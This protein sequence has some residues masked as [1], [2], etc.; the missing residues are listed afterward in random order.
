PAAP[1]ETPDLERRRQELEHFA[2]H[3][4]RKAERLRRQEE[5]LAR[6]GER[7]PEAPAA[8]AAPEP[9]V[10]RRE[11]LEGLAEDL[12]EQVRQRDG[13]IGSGGAPGAGWSRSGPG[14]RAG[15]AAASAPPSAG[16]SRR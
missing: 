14:A 9:G 7:P 8:P 13:L 12:R 5:M 15:R 6:P 11:V 2:A 3:L 1:G 4:R 16:C 10:I